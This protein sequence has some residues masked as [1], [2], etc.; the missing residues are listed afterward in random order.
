MT[1]YW[2]S[3]VTM[4]LSRVVS[5]IFDVAKLSRPW[6]HSQ[7]PVKVIESGIIL[8]L[9]HTT[10]GGQRLAGRPTLFSGFTCSSYCRFCV[11]LLSV[12]YVRFLFRLRMFDVDRQLQRILD[13]LLYA[14]IVFPKISASLMLR[15]WWHLIWPSVKHIPVASLGGRGTQLPPVA[16]NEGAKTASTK[17]FN[18]RKSEFDE[19]SRMSQ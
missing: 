11:V 2:C 1:S 17:Y 3:I 5:E 10:E 16:A 9:C 14:E 8:S 18:D 7:E 19:V 13:Y 6:N 15:V 4:A 12:Q